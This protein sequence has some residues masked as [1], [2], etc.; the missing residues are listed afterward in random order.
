M[1]SEQAVYFPELKQRNIFSVISSPEIRRSS[2]VV[3]TDMEGP[4]ILGDTVAEVMS[5]KILHGGIIY[6]A[7]YDWYTETTSSRRRTRENRYPNGLPPLSAQEG[8]DIIFTLPLLIAAGTDENYIQETAMKYGRTP[9][10]EKFLEYL[11]NEGALVVGVT[12]SLEEP[13]KAI[14][15]EIG[16]NDVIGTPFPLDQAR[17]I[18]EKPGNMAEIAK[19]NS[20]LHDCDAIIN[21][22][23]EYLPLLKERI[24]FFYENELG[25]S[26]DP[27]VRR[28][29][30]GHKTVIGAMIE[31][32]GV[33]GDR[34]KAAIALALKRS[35]LIAGGFLVTI[36]DGTND[37]AMLGLPEARLSIALNGGP[38]KE[39]KIGVITND[40]SVLISLIE[41]AKR[42]PDMDID[43][44]I[45][46]AQRDVKNRAIIHK[47]GPDVAPEII[48]KHS[49]MKKI[50]RGQLGTVVP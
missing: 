4:Q 36:G 14:G 11:K 5:K 28:Q 23:G 30:V 38:V 49:E 50:L 47:G 39:A 24:G 21:E 13:N 18:L 15:R 16:L 29:R 7:T 9:G 17:E 35:K 40:M 31:E 22:G 48:K 33:V 26:Y 6:R 8:T 1:L 43:S 27:E 41:I 45:I 46:E 20:F 32:I 34:S 19:T 10:S 25:V 37:A 2:L 12:T 42:N 3:A 44:I